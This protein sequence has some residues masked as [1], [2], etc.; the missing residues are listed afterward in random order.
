MTTWDGHIEDIIKK[1]NKACY[2]IRNVKLIVSMKTL[3]SVYF[4]YFH[5][6]MSYSI[7]LWGNSSHAERLLRLQKRAV[8]IIK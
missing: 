1:L 3:K 4:S 6:V 8:K 5:S 2:M 7:M